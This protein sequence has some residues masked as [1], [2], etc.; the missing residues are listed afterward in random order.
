MKKEKNLTGY[1]SIDKPWLKYYSEEAINEELPKCTMYELL[2][3]SNK[4][5]LDNIAL[6]YYG[7]KFSYKQVFD[8]IEKTARAF[9]ALGVKKGDIVLFNDPD[10]ADL[11]RRIEFREVFISR[12]IGTAGDTL[13]LNK[14]L[15]DA[16]SGVWSPDNKALYVYPATL[17]DTVQAILDSVGIRGNPLVGY[18]EEG[19]FI[20]SFSRYEFYLI[21]Q[22]GAG[23]VAFTPLNAKLADE[24]RP[25][26]VPG[27]GVSVAVHPWNAVLLCNTIVSHE[28]RKAT[29]KGDTLWVEG[30]PVR[31]YTFSKNYYWMAADD[32]VNL[33]DSRLFGFVP[34]ECIIGQAWRIWFTSRKERFLQ[35]VE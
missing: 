10:P 22:K 15:I 29:V 9:S 30:K 28:G 24:V 17:E 25:Y 19:D 20:R 33:S 32:P 3:Q 12:C 7:R 6:N 34:E 21:S 27:R 23:R 26:V 31:S 13:L 5:H 2:W 4:N 16:E 8:N 11:S 14:E 18:T 35:R 1:P